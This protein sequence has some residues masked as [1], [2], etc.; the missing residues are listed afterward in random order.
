MILLV[1]TTPVQSVSRRKTHVEAIKTRRLLPAEIKT[2]HPLLS[3]KIKGCTD[4]T[5]YPRLIRTYKTYCSYDRRL[6]S[7][8]VAESELFITQER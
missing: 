7:K 2:K 1:L 4:Q 3:Q 6:T 5:I 8:L